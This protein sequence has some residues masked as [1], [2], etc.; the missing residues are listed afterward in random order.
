MPQ[1]TV[2]RHL[3]VLADEGWARS[4]RVGT[5]NLYRMVIDELDPTRRALWQLTRESVAGW[6][7]LDQDQDRL[8]HILRER[9]AQ[10]SGF[11]TAEAERWDRTR[12]EVYGTGFSRA[13]LAASLPSQAVVADLGCGTGALT[14][15]LAP[16]VSWVHAVDNHPGMIRAARHRLHAMGNVTVHE[17]DIAALPMDGGAC[18][19]ALLTLVLSYQPDL[20]GSL[21]EAGRILKPGGRLVI[22]DLAPHDREEF[23][24]RMQQ[25]HAGLV[26]EGLAALMEQAGLLP[27][28]LQPLPPDDD[29][30]C[31]TLLLATAEKPA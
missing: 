26:P 17:A 14:A 16:H 5:T 30:T 12:Q 6:V 15:D 18:D 19:V 28:L 25:V 21:R 31:P 22:V 10:A 29:S 20:L 1:S 2:S 4:V 7:E 23:R 11:F 9:E 13:A 24:L 8:G 3:K 27:R